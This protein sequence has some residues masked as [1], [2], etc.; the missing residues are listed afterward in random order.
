MTIAEEISDLFG[1]DG[2]NFETA[3]GSSLY[4]ICRGREIPIIRGDSLSYIFSDKS[5]IVT[6]L[7]CWDIINKDCE[8]GFCM[9]CET[10]PECSKI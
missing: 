4:D 6:H 9:E 10:I 5:G 7:E 3:N 8:C 2:L 1:N